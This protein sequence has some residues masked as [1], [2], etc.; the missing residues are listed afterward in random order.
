MLEFEQGLTEPHLKISC[1]PSIAFGDLVET[2]PRLE[3]AI[4][5][6]RAG[7]VVACDVSSLRSIDPE[8]IGVL[9]YL[10]L[11][12]FRAAPRAVV[13]ASAPV[14]EE[15]PL[16]AFVRR[17]DEAG[18]LRVVPCPGALSDAVSE[19]AGA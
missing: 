15:T 5:R 2:A 9:C 6:L 3:Q 19:L 13:V 8:A 10:V 11:C 16:C 12:V 1:G 18:C 4:E 17:A 7:A 14:L